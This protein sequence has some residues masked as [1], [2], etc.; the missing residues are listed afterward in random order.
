MISFKKS[1]FYNPLPYIVM[2][3]IN[4]SQFWLMANRKKLNRTTVAFMYVYIVNLN[5][6]RSYV[7]RVLVSFNIS[8]HQKDPLKFVYPR[9]L[10]DWIGGLGLQ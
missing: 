3:T 5:Y 2:D 9:L 1:D 7:I 4:E 10:V 6:V 8:W